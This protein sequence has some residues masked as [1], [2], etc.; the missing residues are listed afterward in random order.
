M[1]DVNA[2]EQERI[3]NQQPKV[4]NKLS[5]FFAG[6]ATFSYDQGKWLLAAIGLFLLGMVWALGQ[7]TLD[8]SAESRLHKT[9]PIRVSFDVFR[10]Q[11]G[12][13]DVMIIS[14]P[15][16]GV[17]DEALVQR[18]NHLHQAIETQVPYVKKVTSLMNARYSYGEIN[19]EGESDLL[20]EGLLEGWPEKSLA[21]RWGDDGLPQYLLH[22]P[23]YRQRLISTDGQE[24]AILVELEAWVKAEP[25]A[26][27]GT[28]EFVKISQAQSAAAVNAIRQQ[29]A[30]KDKAAEMSLTGTPV[31]NETLTRLVFEGTN[32]TGS[33]AFF[34]T[35]LF[36]GIFF[37]RVSGVII[38]LFV[39][40]GSLLAAIGLMALNGT[41]WTLTFGTMPPI[42]IAIGVADAVHILS[43]FYKKYGISGDKRQAIIDAIAYSAPAVLLTS[44]TTAAG[45]LSFLAA[46]LA[47]IAELGRYTAIAVGFALFFTVTLIPALI[48][49]SYIKPR[50]VKATG[51]PLSE[52]IPQACVAF[53]CRYPKAIS[54]TAI[55]VLVLGIINATSLEFADDVMSNFPDT[56]V[57][58]QDLFVIDEA[59]G[60]SGNM[61]VVI[62]SGK[63]NGIYTIEFLQKLQQASDVLSNQNI[64]GVEL[65]DTYSVLNILKETHKALNNNQSEFY[66]LPMTEK[67]AAQELLLFEMSERDDLLKVVDEDFR[68]A[69]LTLKMHYA[70]GVVYEKMLMQMQQRLDAILG[71]DNA[72]ITGSMALLAESVPHALSS[73]M[74]SYVIALVVITFFMTLMIGD[75]RVGLISMIPNILPIVLILNVMVFLGWKLDQ[76]TIS[77]GAIALGL[78]VD[79]TLHFLYHFKQYWQ[80]LGDAKQASMASIKGCG[81]A[82]FI[83]TIIFASASSTNILSS[84]VPFVVF[85]VSL[86]LVTV[87]ALLSD[88]LVAPALL[89]W[90]FSKKDKANQNTSVTTDTLLGDVI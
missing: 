49:V 43:V 88:L 84:L 27:S 51:V 25:M 31:V 89:V 62:D 53:S 56:E 67:L 38:P 24:T 77:I 6:W 36:L 21:E 82:L 69:R 72:V 14:V 83:T 63:K 13:D 34:L 33:L 71:V 37:R 45:F 80:K 85:G 54:L 55:T 15:S 57:T 23:N 30:K 76:T 74:K 9:D 10:Q 41:P 35:I 22:H 29:V 12:R 1:Q 86:A 52:L 47:A 59:Y 18:I 28:V 70:D 79:D 2:S 75:L 73:M 40:N 39:I 26:D 65:A 78:V 87:L 81:S 68:Y 50:T 3:V 17:Y 20:I 16:D 90:G 64:A 58:K 5:R 11:F 7:M 66:A 44:L 19:A 46:D 42:M 8:M 32:L 60:G 48:S 61:E 4:R